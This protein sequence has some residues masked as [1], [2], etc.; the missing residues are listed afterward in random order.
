MNCPCFAGFASRS[1]RNPP[2]EP[3]RQGSSGGEDPCLV[4][5]EGWASHFEAG[6]GR[7]PAVL[8]MQCFSRMHRIHFPGEFDQDIDDTGIKL[9][10]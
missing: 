4:K 3:G 7:T 9:S 6:V 5:W 8:W 10:S 2:F 1:H